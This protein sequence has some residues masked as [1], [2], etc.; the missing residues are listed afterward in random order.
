M[1]PIILAIIFTVSVMTAITVFVLVVIYYDG[2]H[3]KFRIP[4][5]IVSL[6]STVLAPLVQYYY[7]KKRIDRL[8]QALQMWN[9]STHIGKPQTETD[10]NQYELRLV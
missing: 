6:F 8:G 9:R 3:F 7:Y 10:R 1:P 2:L 5:I 4:S